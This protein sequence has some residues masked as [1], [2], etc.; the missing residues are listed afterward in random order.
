MNLDSHFLTTIFFASISGIIPIL[1]WIFFWTREDKKNPEPKKM[2][3]LA[4]IGGALAVFISL[5]LEKYF[6]GLN[7]ENLFAINIFGD[8]LSYFE[9]IAK[10]IN[11]TLDRVLLI[12]IFAPIIEE[13][14]KFL[15][16]YVFVLRSKVNNEPLDPMIYMIMTALGFSAVENIFFLINPFNIYDYT[17]IIF[18]GNMRFVGATLLH[19]ISSAIIAMFI[20]FHFFDSKI[21]KIFFVILGI[22]CSIIIHS[23][24]NF[25]IIVDQKASFLALILIWIITIIILLAFE[26]IKKIRNN[27]K[28]F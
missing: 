13:I 11:I 7:F 23:I 19:T 15:M 22:I 12:I 27:C 21:K 10:Q 25:L 20:S 14:S 26:K 8:I 2:L 3:A 1:I 9:T 5:F 28:D 4:F 24:F 17:T 6:Y 16:A 18:T